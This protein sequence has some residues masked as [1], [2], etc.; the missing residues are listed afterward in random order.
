MVDAR[1]LAPRYVDSI[2]ASAAARQVV[3]AAVGGDLQIDRVPRCPVAKPVTV[4]VGRVELADPAAA[5]VGEEVVADVARPGTG[6]VAG[7]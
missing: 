7:L 1:A 4:F 2:D 3:E 5:E 6:R